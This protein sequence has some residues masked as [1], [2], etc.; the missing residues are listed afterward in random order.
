MGSIHSQADYGHRTADFF[1]DTSDEEAGETD[2]IA[3]D[4]NLVGRRGSA[5]KKRHQP[6]TVAAPFASQ[7]ESKRPRG[8]SLD[9]QYLRLT[10]KTPQYA[11]SPSVSSRRSV[12]ELLPDEQYPSSGLRIP[13]AAYIVNNRIGL[14][15]FDRSEAATRDTRVPQDRPS[16]LLPDSDK[17]NQVLGVHAIAH[18]ITLQALMREELKFDQN[19]HSS[20]LVTAGGQGDRG[21]RSQHNSLN[22]SDPR[23][24]RNRAFSAISTPASKKVHVVPPPIDTSGPRNSVPANIVRTP[25]PFASPQS[26]RKF[27]PLPISAAT[28]GPFTPPAESLLTISIRRSNP[29]SRARTT[30]VTIPAAP[31]GSAFASPTLPSHLHNARFSFQRAADQTET[32]QH[33]REIDFDDE[34]LFLHLRS[35][36][37]ALVPGAFRYVSARSL[38]RIIVIGSAS[39]AADA[40]Y[41][42][43]A[44]PRGPKRSP[45]HSSRSPQS[46]AWDDRRLTGPGPGAGGSETTVGEE[47]IMQCFQKPKTC[48]GRYA[49]V[50]WARRVGNASSLQ[51]LSSPEFLR[52]KDEYEGGAETSRNRTQHTETEGLEFVVSWSWRRIALALAV[53]LV[54]SIAVALL[55]I[56]I[57]RGG[58]SDSSGLVT[59]GRPA[60]TQGAGGFRDAG[61]RVAAGVLVGICVLLLGVVGV[62]GW[63][64]LSWLVM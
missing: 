61:D 47:K 35:T 49:W 53:V 42:W 36:Y 37:A 22:F 14:N 33:L 29:H 60:A 7:C 63:L 26:Q 58:G 57:G 52:E 62:A 40:R 31:N 41:G 44:S 3:P 50:H 48:R 1:E 10:P 32:E 5:T 39:R 30:T 21:A 18:E 25:Y 54:L 2:S 12:D 9:G 17:V 20:P 51:P 6:S 13:Q 55:W 23:S 28:T 45:G 64:C 4:V 16:Q 59:G 34:T 8:D 15:T 46:T 24:P 56:F 19:H 11:N 27:S 43:L 38:R